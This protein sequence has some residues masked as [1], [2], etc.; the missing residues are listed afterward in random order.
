MAFGSSIQLSN[1]K[2]NWLFKLA[3]NNSGFLYLSF[4]DVIYSSNYYRGVVLNRP[5]I[6]ETISLTKSTA[7]TSGISISIP[8]FDYNG[9]PVS[10]ELF[11][12]T[13]EYINR[14]CTIH[15]KINDDTPV[16]IGSFR[17]ISITT[18]G[19]KLSI[20][21]N[22][23]RPWDLITLPNVKTTDRKLLVPIAYG[24]YT[25]NPASTEASP[26]FISALTSYAYRPVEY[27]KPFEGF[28]I[29]P[30]SKSGSDSE[31]AVYNEQFDVF[32]PTIDAQ[33]TTVSTDTSVDHAKV[34]PKAHHIF[35]VSPDST[36]DIVVDSE[37]TVNNLSYVYDENEST[38]ATFFADFNAADLVQAS[39]YLN[40]DVP[41]EDQ[42][43][44]KLQDSNGNDIHVNDTN[45]F[46][47]S[48]TSFG[49]DDA[50]NL[51][52]GS[53]LKLKEEIMLVTNISSNTLTVT[54]GAFNTTAIAHEDD[55][56]IF[57]T[58]N[59]NILSMK[60]KLDVVSAGSSGASE[61]YF[62]IVVG[63]ETSLFDSG[64]L[65]ANVSDNT[66]KIPF[67]S[68]SKR[69]VL[70]MLWFGDAIH[71]IE[72]TFTVYDVSVTASRGFRTPP[73][74]LYVA[75]DGNTHNITGLAGNAITSINNI[76]LD[77]LNRFSGLD[78]ATNPATNIDGFSAVETDRSDWGARLYFTKEQSYKKI[79]EKIQFEGCF[80]FRYKQ[81]DST[82]PQ[83]LHVKD[84]YS[85]SEITTLS[86]E[87]ISGVSLS[88]TSVS[89]LLTKFIVNYKK[90]PANNTY[91]DQEE[92]EVSADRTKYN[93]GT[94]ENIKTFN[95]DYLMEQND[96]QK[97]TNPNDSFI[98]YYHNLL[99]TPK[100]IISFT[101]V[102][103]KYYDLEVGSIINF[104]NTNMYPPAPFGVS[105][106]WSDLKFMITKTGRTIGK[107]SVTA[108]QIS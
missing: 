39:Y 50:S 16:K 47:A 51:F 90:H 18:D 28:A 29:Y 87:D 106:G 80:I 37:V 79:L 20:K 63:N 65:Y 81:G 41:E 23:H 99:G 78:V 56:D 11:G 31:M 86:K 9:N 72:G 77:L 46:G 102:S 24:D 88:H 71:P 103:P 68:G 10:K 21:M 92:F 13:N 36:T 96:I 84:S 94:L 108:R 43:F 3:N 45:G 64:K 60:Y 58:I 7:S 35:K 82:Q 93:I 57:T 14:E 73:K 97:Q 33:G 27:N 104:N 59:Y 12:G 2:E 76:H 95:L 66:V 85:S 34:E 105:N 100:L 42:S 91:R 49:I 40:I 17:I 89:D 52:V 19:D 5:T 75:S 8:D 107:I 101:I 70:A 98:N 32:V 22:S 6:S 69:L 53:V 67:P 26:K 61:S 54:R 38:G 1:I 25:K 30:T 4:A 55:E 15:S 48:A 74:T 44:Q 83:Y 62:N